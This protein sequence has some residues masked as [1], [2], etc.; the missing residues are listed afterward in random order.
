A[1]Q[2][3]TPKRKEVRIPFGSLIEQGLIEPG[4]QLFDLTRR[5]SAMVRA[6]GSLVSGSHQGSIHKVG[7]LVQ[8]SE[9]CNGWTFWHHQTDLGVAPIDDLR[10]GIRAKLDLLSA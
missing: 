9:A 4:T 2:S 7:A 5:Y 1:L 3:V 6:D 8:G 10:T